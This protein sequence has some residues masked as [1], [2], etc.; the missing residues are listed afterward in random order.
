MLHHIY[1]VAK[2]TLVSA[3]GSAPGSVYWVV[4]ET[5]LKLV[6]AGSEAVL[7]FFVLSGLVVALPA[8]R[9]PGFSWTGFLTGRMVRIYLP[10]WASLAIGTALIWL[11]PR[12]QSVVTAGSWMSQS[13][14]TAVTPSTLWGQM[15]LTAVSYD[16]N[17]VLWSLRWE[18]IFS[19]LLPLFV[20][21]A[22]VVRRRWLLAG[23]VAFILILLGTLA[24]ID[25]LKYLPV[26]FIGT[27]LAVRLDSINEWTRQRLKRP[28]ATLW[29]IILVVGVLLLLVARW[30]AGSLA[31]FGTLS[32]S[33]LRLMP[34]LGAAGLVWAAIGVPF[35][36][37]ALDSRPGQW[38][39]RISF[40]L[41]LIHIPILATLT[42]V[43]GDH[44]WWLVAV[45]TVPVAL[46]AAWGF[47]RVIE[48][49]SH[50]LARYTSQ[51]TARATAKFRARVSR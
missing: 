5:P 36:R 29:G 26:F 25:A 2:P 30:W 23:A 41:Y 37:R 35:L 11:L 28:R 50:R 7:V 48:R 51:I 21:V 45:L 47:Y 6:T 27:L 10:V 32:D 17:N 15:S 40:S 8:L 4:S 22:Q 3:G 18:L 43:L 44:K 49:P 20:A 14:A 42:F 38:L 34:V 33:V 24:H 16:I 19:V 46:V 31:S 12:D 9:K 1:L 13:N 39:G